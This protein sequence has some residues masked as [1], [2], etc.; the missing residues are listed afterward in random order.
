MVTPPVVETVACRF[1]MISNSGLVGTIL[2]GMTK[3]TTGWPTLTSV[4]SARVLID[5][6]TNGFFEEKQMLLAADLARALKT[7]S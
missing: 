5:Q 6:A 3:F 4:E 1:G 7:I 2:G